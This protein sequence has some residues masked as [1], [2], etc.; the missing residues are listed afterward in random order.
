VLEPELS[1]FSPVRMSSTPTFDA[2]SLVRM[3]SPEQLAAL[4]AAAAP[5]K[6]AKAA[7]SPPPPG[8]PDAS[9]YR[10]R[11][12]DIDETVC[13]GRIM[14]ETDKDRRWAPV[15]YFEKQ[16]GKAIVIDGLC[17]M[18]CARRSLYEEYSTETGR[19]KTWNGVVTEEPPAWTHML[20]TKWAQ[21]K[22][23]R[24]VGG[25]T[26][27]DTEV[28]SVS[29]RMTVAAFRAEKVKEK[30]AAKVADAE[31]KAAE[32]KA[33][34]DSA[35]AEKEAEK[36]R[37]AEEKAKALAEKEAE[38][39]RRAEEKERKPRTAKEAVETAR[40]A[41]QA[42]K[43]AAEAERK[44]QE[45]ARLAASK[46]AAEAER[47]QQ[48]EA[49]L[50]AAKK[51][52]T[53]AQRLLDEAATLESVA[54]ELRAR[55]AEHSRKA[56]AIDPTP[57]A[58]LRVVEEVEEVE[59]AEELVRTFEDVSYVLR[60]SADGNFYVYEFDLETMGAGDYKGQANMS[61]DDLIGIDITVSEPEDLATP[62]SI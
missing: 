30:E 32:L 48:E 34:R 11:P 19:M 24:W 23:P 6:A 7:P 16:C 5:A 54:R 52:R 59:E 36:K 35:A 9:H 56:E 29:S 49:R 1:A 46:K 33:K 39:K 53:E 58:S 12:E 41:L 37:R 47:K 20:G 22:Q 40:M 42:A 3:L 13:V 31:K 8:A 25:E 4:V 28:S 43:K 60:K 45:E 62:L 2:A 51:E 55:A 10:L 61:G 38:K 17:S 27:A 57:L 14:S 50:A 44:R 15:I 26:V 21:R 18:C